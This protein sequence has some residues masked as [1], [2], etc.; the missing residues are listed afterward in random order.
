[1]SDDNGYRFNWHDL[2]ETEPYEAFLHWA[3]IHLTVDTN[4][5]SNPQVLT[6]EQLDA[7]DR[8]TDRFHDVELTIQLNGIDVNPE[9][10][11]RA[12]ER[13]M[14]L[15]ARDAAR[16]ELEQLDDL[17]LLRR[18]VVQLDRETS[19]RVRWVAAKLGI[20]LDPDDDD[21]DDVD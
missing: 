14:K 12:I 17:R 7:L 15:L 9:H 5:E 3:V 1:M 21:P 13:N 19:R 2:D 11:M 4:D 18:T 8:A 6:D 16:A 10:M 20:T